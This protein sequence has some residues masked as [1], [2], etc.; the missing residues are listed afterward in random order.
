MRKIMK[1]IKGY[2]KLLRGIIRQFDSFGYKFAYNF[3]G[4]E[5]VYTTTVGGIASIGMGCVILYFFFQ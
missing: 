4:N 2:A 1:Y 5:D 3:E